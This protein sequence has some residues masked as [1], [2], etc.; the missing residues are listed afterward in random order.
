M[1]TQQS[2][3]AAPRPWEKQALWMLMAGAAIIR[4]VY[5]IPEIPDGLFDDGYTTF[6]YAV[7][8]VRGAGLV[9]NPGER[10]LGTTSPLFTFMLAGAGRVFGLGHLETIAL[11]FNILASVGMLYFTARILSEVGLE[12]EVKWAYLA[13]LAFL[14]SFLA[15]GTSGMETPVVIFLMS[16]SL[17][18]CIRN[19]LIAVAIVGVLLFLS[20][21][22]AGIWLLG[23]GIHLLLTKR[24]RILRDLTAPLLV[25]L[26]GVSA[27][28]IFAK[29]YFGSIIPQSI[30]GKAVSHGAFGM[31][32]WQYA[33]QFLSA[34]IP[35]ARFGVWGL[36]LIVVLFILLVPAAIRLSSRYP[37]LRPMLYFPPLYIGIFLST[38]SPLFSWYVMPPKW[39]FYLLVTYGIWAVARW[40]RESF[41]L[42]FQ[43]SQVMA[44]IGIIVFALGLN[45]VR[46][47]LFNRT[48]NT[49][50]IISEMVDRNVQPDGRVFL[51][52]IGLFGYKTGRFIY[53]YMGLVTP[54]T[55]R[56][57]R[58]YGTGWLTKGAREFNAD[59]VI[60]YP[61]DIP[62]VQST[63]D[64]DAVWF[65]K[66]Y[67]HVK[68]Y[69][70]YGMVISVYFKNDSKQI[71]T[72]MTPAS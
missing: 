34:F 52:H 57:K 10:V 33:L 21:M 53:D 42:P 38:R 17:W 23:L 15:N 47:Q 29:A 50:Q 40:G 60:L 30:V 48:P 18:L 59:V 51:E 24:E 41:H 3:P 31:P 19:R 2:V 5:A 62:L 66:N 16:L 1:T 20:R 27:W 54:E 63:T 7:N 9:F 49:W 65:Q 35:A 46:S 8:L 45:D 39:A 14:P 71:V 68:D 70:A 67:R 28:L 6:R 58:Q 56:L 25:F 37:G 72:G 43:P 44:L 61:T 22:D 32:D 26:A 69:E 4:I 64:E 36:A 12:V 11:T 55:T 13:V